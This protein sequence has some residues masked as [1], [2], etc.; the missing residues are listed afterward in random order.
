MPEAEALDLVLDQFAD[1]SVKGEAIQ[2]AINIARNL[3]KS[4]KEDANFFTGTDLT[5]WQ[6]NTGYWHVEDGA[7]VGRSDDRVV[8]R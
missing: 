4:A 8:W 1:E 5:G 7:I 3:G 2:A 6:G